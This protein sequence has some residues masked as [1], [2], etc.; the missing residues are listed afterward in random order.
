MKNSRIAKIIIMIVSVLAAMIVIDFVYTRYYR[1]SAKARTHEQVESYINETLQYNESDYDN[2]L[3]DMR[4]LIALPHISDSD[5]GHV[6]ERMAQIYKFKNDTLNFYHTMG[7]ALYY[8]EKAGNKSV[9]VNIYED[10]A[11]YYVSECNY[12]Q[13]ENIMQNVYAICPINEIDD[14]QVKSYAYRMEAILARE[15]GDL[16]AA[17]SFIEE[18]NKILEPN[19]DQLWCPSYVAIND[20]VRA[21]IMYDSKDFDGARKMLEEYRDSEFFSLSIYADIMTRDFVLPYYDTACKLAAYDKDEDRLL[22]LLDKCSAVSSQYGFRNK[23]LN[24]ILDILKGDYTLSEAT[25]KKLTETTLLIYSQITREQSDD[26]AAMINSPLDNGIREQEDLARQKYEQALAIRIYA[27]TILIALIII[28]VLT[29]V[30]RR[31]FIDPLTGIGNRRGLDKYLWF[32]RLFHNNIHT[33][34]IDADNFKRV[35]D[36]YG[37]D[38]GDVVLKRIGSLLKA[39]QTA[40]I[41]SF[42]YGGEEFVVV[43]KRLSDDTAIR[44]AENIRR[45]VEWQTWDFPGRITVSIGLAFGNSSLDTVKLADECMYHSKQNG[46][47]SVSYKDG[48]KM[49]QVSKGSDDR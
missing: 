10:I 34:M 40:N 8:L 36:N 4:A 22:K 2:Y 7:N 16:N 12:D 13:A 42:R 23:E 15:S 45:D 26:Y 24:I 38:Q 20:A 18:S 31:S 35:N 3:A 1:E 5:K 6:Y 19:M 21:G 25:R 29:L 44:I 39:M 9:A 32:I 43:L 46:K 28:T 33:M 37:H 14:P 11:N 49:C 30:I 48:E 17:M 41:R 27:A 47:N